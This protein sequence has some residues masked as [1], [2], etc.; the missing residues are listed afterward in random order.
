MAAPTAPDDAGRVSG[1]SGGDVDPAAP[2]PPPEPPRQGRK[3]KFPT[4]FTVLAGVLLLVWIASFFVPPGAYSKDAT[5]SPKPGT[6]AKL[7]SCDA[8]AASAPGLNV[9]SPTESGQAPADALAAPGAT[10][11]DIGIP[12]ADKSFTFRFKQLWNAPPTG[13]Y[14]GEKSNGFGGAS[15]EGLLYG[16]AEIFFLFFSVGGVSTITIEMT[17]SPTGIG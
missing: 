5:G 9:E 17:G 12:C 16:S 10:V 3:F 1:V 4:A 6:Y 11:S 8:A 2:A 7:P 14:G 15:E 13:L